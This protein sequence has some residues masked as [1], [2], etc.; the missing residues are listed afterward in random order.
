MQ[1]PFAFFNIPPQNHL[2]ESQCLQQ[3]YKISMCMYQIQWEIVHITSSTCKTLLQ[4]C[5]TGPQVYNNRSTTKFFWGMQ[6]QYH[7]KLLLV[8]VLLNVLA[9]SQDSQAVIHAAEYMQI[10]FQNLF[11][12]QALFYAPFNLSKVLGMLC[13]YCRPACLRKKLQQTIQR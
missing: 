8:V 10:Y 3:R 6:Q 9:A 1:I 4:S 11:P 12:V 7:Q 13:C 5:R 2:L